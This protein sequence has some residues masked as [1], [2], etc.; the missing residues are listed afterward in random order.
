RIV[1]PDQRSEWFFRDSAKNVVQHIDSAGH[2]N[3]FAHDEN[4]NLLEH[5]RADGTTVHYAWDSKDQLI[6][7]S[8]A[9]GGL[10]LRD[11]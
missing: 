1:H 11:Y 6:K 2:V 10:W 9:E 4:G 8:D 3:R 5:I 7:I